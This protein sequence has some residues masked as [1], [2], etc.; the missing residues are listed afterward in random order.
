SAQAKLAGLVAHLAHARPGGEPKPAELLVRT[1]GADIMLDLPR[2]RITPTAEF[3]AWA[4]RELGPGGVEFEA[5]KPEMV[6][7]EAKPWERKRV[8]AGSD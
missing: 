7:R 8:P 1:P 6:K 5:K 2:T 4:G 3:L